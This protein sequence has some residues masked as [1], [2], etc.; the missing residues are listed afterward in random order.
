MRIFPFFSFRPLWVDA[1]GVVDDDDLL[2][3]WCY[4]SFEESIRNSPSP[5]VLMITNWCLLG[6]NESIPVWNEFLSLS[7]CLYVYL[8]VCLW[9]V[10]RMQL[11]GS[12]SAMK[13]K[14][15]KTTPTTTTKTK[16]IMAAFVILIGGF[17]DKTSP[18]GGASAALTGTPGSAG[19]CLQSQYR[20]SSGRCVNLNLFCDGRND[21]GDNS[22][23]P[24]QCTRK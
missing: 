7:V 14:K 3:F 21:C 16:S 2:V 17:Y 19:G 5:R 12:R 20:C 1:T 9:C 23:E 10:C 18:T 15:T 22:D 13:K 8:T 11:G 6:G 24:A 4:E